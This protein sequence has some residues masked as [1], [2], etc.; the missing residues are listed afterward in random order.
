[1]RFRLAPALL[2]GLVLSAASSLASAADLK[3]GDPVVTEGLQRVREGGE[4]RLPG[5]ESKTEGGT[6]RLAVK[7]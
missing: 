6:D 1:M 5:R 4:V 2:A 7:Q 3:I